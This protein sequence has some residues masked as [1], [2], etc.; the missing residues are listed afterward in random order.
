[1]ANKVPLADHFLTIGPTQVP[2]NCPSHG[3]LQVCAIT[4]LIQDHYTSPRSPSIHLLLPLTQ[5]VSHTSGTCMLD[6]TGDRV[7][8]PAKPDPH[9]L[10]FNAFSSQVS[11]FRSQDIRQ[12]L[13]LSPWPASNRTVYSG[14]PDVA[15][16]ST[17]FPTHYSYAHHT[18]FPW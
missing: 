4:L 17:S 18:L 11:L 10:L 3:L 6:A 1:M 14:P 2:A 9:R 16:I 7:L 13:T 8:H 12:A 5:S 15:S